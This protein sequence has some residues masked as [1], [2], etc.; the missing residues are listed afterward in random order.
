MQAEN[1]LITV[2]N[3]DRHNWGKLSFDFVTG[4]S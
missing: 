1:E 2:S 4:W 3:N